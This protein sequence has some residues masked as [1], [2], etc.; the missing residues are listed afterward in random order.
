MTGLPQIATE[1]NLKRKVF[2]ILVF[3]ACLFGFVYQLTEFLMLY[4]TYPTTL[5]VLVKFTEDELLPKPVITTCDVNGIR[6]SAFCKDFPSHCEKPKN[7]SLFCTKNSQF[8]EK[9]NF[10]DDD[11]MFPTPFAYSDMD[12]NR[13]I[14]EDYG[15]MAED[16]LYIY[17]NF[18]RRVFYANE[19]WKVRSCYSIDLNLIDPNITED[20]F[21]A[22]KMYSN[23]KTVGDVVITF[24]SKELFRP[25]VPVGAKISIHSKDQIVNP[26]V[27]G[28]LVKPGN[29]YI[30]QL[31][32][33][34]ENLLTNP[35]STNCSYYERSKEKSFDELYTRQR[36]ILNCQKEKWLEICG[37]ISGDYP[38]ETDGIFCSEQTY[39]CLVNLNT[40]HCFHKCQIACQATVFEYEV[41]DAPIEFYDFYVPLEIPDEDTN[42]NYRKQQQVA[43]MNFFFKRPELLIYKYK[44][45]FQ[46][47]ELF[48][49]VGGYIGMWLGISLIAIFDFLEVITVYI[50]HIIT[51]DIPSIENY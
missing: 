35:Y 43:V 5:E 15:T 23:T 39:M 7:V 8:C 26:F 2:K 34:E 20:Y 31:K 47:I 41:D 51:R 29:R 45:K 46:S 12:Y 30:I 4:F 3:F 17:K 18:T 50:Y 14:I 27:D 19:L 1:H 33:I 16:I 38:F 36:C 37:C 44:P 32:V 9:E 13:T 21:P 42:E 48:G 11:L 6:R 25:T 22:L 10:T 49:Y 40:D 28:F 24:N